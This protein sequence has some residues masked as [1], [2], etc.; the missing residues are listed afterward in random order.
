MTDIDDSSY[1]HCSVADVLATAEVEKRH[2]YRAAT[3]ECRAS[4]LPF[5]RLMMRCCFGITLFFVLFG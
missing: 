5:V 2:K 1:V 4:F 3:E